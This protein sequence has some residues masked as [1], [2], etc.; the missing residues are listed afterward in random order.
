MPE[1]LYTNLSDQPTKY[2]QRLHPAY[3]EQKCQGKSAFQK[4]RVRGPPALAPH[5]LRC[6]GAA[7]NLRKQVRKHSVL[8]H[9]GASKTPG[10][11][12]G[13]H[14]CNSAESQVHLTTL[15]LLLDV[16]PK[17]WWP[18]RPWDRPESPGCPHRKE[19]LLSPPAKKPPWQKVSNGKSQELRQTLTAR[20]LPDPTG[21]PV[22]VR[23]GLVFISPF[24]KRGNAELEKEFAAYGTQQLLSSGHF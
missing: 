15:W 21:L 23:F 9:G 2:L 19:K 7:F 5:R 1:Y 4:Q 14:H 16:A 17:G 22:I 20:W 11:A 13:F 10:S 6:W 3:T 24:N 18:A 12:C 8:G